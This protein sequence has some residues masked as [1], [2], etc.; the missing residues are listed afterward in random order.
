MYM[1]TFFY[2]DLNTVE[3]YTIHERKTKQKKKKTIK[4]KNQV[5]KP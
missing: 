3:K 2:K 4:V 5:L 1:Q